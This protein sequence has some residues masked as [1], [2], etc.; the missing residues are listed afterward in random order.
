PELVGA[1]NAVREA[2]V[3]EPAHVHGKLATKKLRRIETSWFRDPRIVNIC[4]RAIELSG[5][6]P[7]RLESVGLVLLIPHK[8]FL[9]QEPGLTAGIER[10]A[11][12]HADRGET[13]AYKYHPNSWGQELE[14]PRDQCLEIPQRLPV[15]I[16]SPWLSNAVVAG[17]MTSS[18]I[19]L[20]RL[21]PGIQPR[22]LVLPSNR[23]HPLNL[24]YRKLGIPLVECV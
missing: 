19:F 7:A 23:E 4:S 3:M 10:L 18:L 8:N 24:V 1:A 13:V 15:E 14:L 2:W 5:L 21:N 9:K 16:L 6:E 20:P 11:R 12:E 22:A 17:S